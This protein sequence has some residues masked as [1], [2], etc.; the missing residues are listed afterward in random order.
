MFP[1]LF[2]R[3]GVRLGVVAHVFRCSGVRLGVVPH[4]FRCLGVRRVGAL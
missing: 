1:M 4:V 2:E 3:L